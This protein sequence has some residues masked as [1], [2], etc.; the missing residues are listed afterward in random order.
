MADGFRIKVV[1]KEGASLYDF[2]GLAVNV[3]HL[4]DFAFVPEEYKNLPSVLIDAVPR[5]SQMLIQH[6]RAEHMCS[7]TALS[8]L[9]EYLGQQPINLLDTALKVY[10]DGLNAFGSWPF[11][12]AHAFDYCKGSFYF[13]IAR[14]P[15]FREL[16]AFLVRKIPVIVSVRGP[17]PGGAGEYAHG[18]LM[19]VVGWDQERQEVLCHDS[20]FPA[21]EKVFVSY[22]IKDFCQAWA[23]SHNLAYV[24]E[25]RIIPIN[26]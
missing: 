19:L 15:S 9:L 14:L 26:Y 2:R 20:A 8:M 23:R 4:R 5:Y 6:E 7:P 11:N 17:L 16:H 12:I 24:A 21:D 22:K 10:D 3:A 1:P 25:E 13:Y 18:H